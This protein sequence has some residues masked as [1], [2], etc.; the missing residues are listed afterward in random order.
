MY[1]LIK[2]REIY[3]IHQGLYTYKH[4]DNIDRNTQTQTYVFSFLKENE[5]QQV[6]MSFID[7]RDNK[8]RTTKRTA[9][10]KRKKKEEN[11]HKKEQTTSE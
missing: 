1:V 9:K 7:V 3:N 8:E 5:D 6:Y 11:R 2:V 10:S 4:R